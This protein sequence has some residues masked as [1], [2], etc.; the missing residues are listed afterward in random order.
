[1]Q[2]LL[3]K[4]LTNLADSRLGGGENCAF[5]AGKRLLGQDFSE[6]RCR[7][8]NARAGTAQP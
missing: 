7:V 2:V 4:R 3:L 6:F 5:E 1:M 8:R